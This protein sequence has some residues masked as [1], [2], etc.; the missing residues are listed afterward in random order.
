MLDT[1]WA[2][3]ALPPLCENDEE[4]FEILHR[5]IEQL[6]KDVVGLP[7]ALSV[8]IGKTARTYTDIASIEHGNTSPQ[9]EGAEKRGRAVYNSRHVEK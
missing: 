7:Q 3:R 6:C 5:T 1:F 4:A 9:P 2:P 8:A